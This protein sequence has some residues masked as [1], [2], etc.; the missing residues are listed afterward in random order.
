MSSPLRYVD[1]S[2]ARAI[3]HARICAQSPA[4]SP[5]ASFAV[6]ILLDRQSGL[7]KPWSYLESIGS[8]RSPAT[9][10]MT[11]TNKVAGVLIGEAVSPALLSAA[12]LRVVGHIRTD[13]LVRSVS[14]AKASSSDNICSSG[15]TAVVGI[16]FPTLGFTSSRRDRVSSG[17]CY[18]RALASKCSD[19]EETRPREP[20]DMHWSAW[21]RKDTALQ[22]RSGS[23]SCVPCSF[24]FRAPTLFCFGGLAQTRTQPES[25]RGRVFANTSAIFRGQRSDRPSKQIVWW[26]RDPFAVLSDLDAR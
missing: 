21:Q 4:L 3:C 25:G 17:R 5:H 7:Q 15:T 12:S 24:E 2:C 16:S 10:L 1:P 23:Q 13:R 6:E 11:V 9:T 22:S 19:P 26:Q 8:L 20:N 18:V 14:A